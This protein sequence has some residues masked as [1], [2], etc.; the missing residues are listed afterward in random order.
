MLSLE[1]GTKK[2]KN[3]EETK[4]KIQVARKKRIVIVR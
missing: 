1:H 3:N 2:R 4:N